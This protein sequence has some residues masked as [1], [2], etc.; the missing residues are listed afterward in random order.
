[1]GNKLGDG[2]LDLR[3]AWLPEESLGD[4]LFEVSDT[5]VVNK[6]RKEDADVIRES[7][8]ID[9]ISDVLD[10]DGIVNEVPADGVME[11]LCVDVMAAVVMDDTGDVMF[12]IVTDVI[13]PDV[14]GNIN[15]GNDMIV[16]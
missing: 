8:V 4:S 7:D 11:I 9:D 14:I 1:M 5:L 2:V 10:T 3:L 15:I 6:G 16:D 13:L 12:A